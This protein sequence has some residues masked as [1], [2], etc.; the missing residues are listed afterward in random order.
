MKTKS[1]IQIVSVLF[2]SSLTLLTTNVLAQTAGGWLYLGANTY[3]NPLGNSVGI[4]IATPTAPLDIANSTKGIQLRA[5]NSNTGFTNNQL[6]FSYSGGINY[7]HAIKTRHNSNALAGNAIDFFVWNYGVDAAGTIG[8][9]NVMT[10]DGN[11]NVGVG[12]TIPLG[13]LQVGDGIIKVALGECYGA[14]TNY[15]TSYIGFNAARTTGGWVFNTDG[16]SNGGNIIYGNVG[17]HMLFVSMPSSGAVT[18][19]K[20]DAD[21]INATRMI[22]TST[23]K[24]GI[25]TTNPNADLTV[26]GTA[27][28]G[29][30]TAVT[31]LPAGYKLYVQT[32]ILTEKVKVAVVGTGNWSDYV[33]S[34]D[35]KLRSI[36]ELENY[37]LKHKHLP[38]IPSAEEVVK[39][40]IDV[41]TMDAKLLEK[42]E[43]LSLY[44]I[45]QNKRIEL[46]EQKFATKK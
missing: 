6:L 46:L 28:I 45:Q 20:T 7:T 36:G 33:F 29:D 18:Q 8:T 21:I 19:T 26:N 2:L 44:I 25:K 34:A 35:Y 11:G 17:G 16:A 42:I 14:S 3:T 13:K 22:I 12:S 43:E 23:G 30:P 24:V 27:L 4:G 38:N 15:G 37:L 9:K 40:G 5:G 1:K 31:S 41:A 39:E 10:L 32:G